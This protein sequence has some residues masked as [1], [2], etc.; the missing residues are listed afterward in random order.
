MPSFSEA[1]VTDEQ[2]TDI[3]AYLTSLPV[4]A[5]NGFIQIELAD[6]A[7]EGQKLIV[8]KRCVAC[9]TE[10]G[11]IKGFIERGETPTVERVITQLRTPFKNM[12]SFSEAQV[13]DEEAATIAEFLA[14][15]FAAPAE[16]PQ[17]GHSSPSQWPLI[18]L[19][20]GSLVVLG[21]VVTRWVMLRV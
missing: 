12:P 19:L 2:L 18:L 15:E 17:S 8:E 20:A 16:L 7:P 9:H 5:Q 3:N 1:Q 13:S 14:E 4:P 11:P 10:T 21:G 6:D